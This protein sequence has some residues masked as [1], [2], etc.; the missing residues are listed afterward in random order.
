MRKIFERTGRLNNDTIVTT[1]MSNLGLYK[2]CDK[3]G[4]KYEKTAVGINMYM[5]T[6]CRTTI[7]SEESSQDILF[8]ANMRQQVMVS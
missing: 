6:W 1:I 5:R 2:A 7:V 4:I 3:A 8:S